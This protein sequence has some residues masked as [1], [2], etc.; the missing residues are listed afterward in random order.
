MEVGHLRR[1]LL[2][3]DQAQLDVYLQVSELVQDGRLLGLQPV[4]VDPGVDLDVLL[5]SNVA[6]MLV[7][8]RDRNPAQIKSLAARQNGG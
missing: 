1:R 8:E 7:D 6:E 3:A 5:L 4:P 2:L